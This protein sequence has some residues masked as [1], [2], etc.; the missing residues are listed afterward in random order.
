MTLSYIIPN[1]EF[2]PVNIER[3]KRGKREVRAQ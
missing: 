2:T 1:M 3:V